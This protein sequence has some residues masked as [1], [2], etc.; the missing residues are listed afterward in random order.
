MPRAHVKTD[1]SSTLDLHEDGQSLPRPPAIVSE[2]PSVCADQ[3]RMSN[4]S[5]AVNC[6][7]LKKE[8]LRSRARTA[9]QLLEK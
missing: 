6:F 5:E 7:S 2:R 3:K 1:E 4:K 8:K 9:V